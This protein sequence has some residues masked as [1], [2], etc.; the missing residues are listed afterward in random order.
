MQAEPHAEDT[1]QTRE[2]PA[3]VRGPRDRLG[4]ASA[5]L[6]AKPLL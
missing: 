4:G 1:W 2:P 3:S 5:L 6:N